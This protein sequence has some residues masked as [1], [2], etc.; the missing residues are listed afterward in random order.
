MSLPATRSPGPPGAGPATTPSGPREALNGLIGGY[1]ATQLVGVAAR[2]GIADLLAGGGRDAADLAAAAGAHPDALG[3]VLR[4]LVNLGVLSEDGAGRFAL[5][6]C[7]AFLRRD[8][9][10]SLHAWAIWEGD[11]SYRAWAALDHSVATGE[12]A[13][14]R[15]LG[16]PFFE[17]FAA[18]PEAGA[19]FDAAM[20]DYTAT[21]AAAV[22]AGYDF[23]AGSTVVDVGGGRGHVLRAVL[24]AHPEVRG[25]LFD[26][27]AVL[28]AGAAALAAAGLAGRASAVA[29]DFFAAVPA[30]ADVYLLCHIVHDWDDARAVRLLRSC[31]AAVAPEG[32]LL[33]V[34]KLMPEPMVCGAVPP[35]TDVNMLV[36]TGGRERTEREYRALLAAAGWRLRRVRPTASVAS[37]FEA[38]P[39]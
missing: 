1:R 17:H 28:T 23:G 3:R 13:F 22:A 38:A 4:A 15:V 11:T 2:L 19:G 8:V 39:V 35:G 14:D 16:R 29:G 9:P 30:G 5:T 24:L 26:L 36:L 31:R 21:I 18:H 10:G 6:A 37:L 7:G 27:P 20:V 25:V 33:I 32:C 12:T 34:E